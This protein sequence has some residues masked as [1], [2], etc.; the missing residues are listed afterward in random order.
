MIILINIVLLILILS[1]GTFAILFSIL[2]LDSLLRGHDIPTS[3]RVIKVLSKIISQNKSY[4]NNFYDLGCGRGTLSLAI[5]R[6][7]P[8]LSVH[9]IDDN[10]IRIFFARIK[11]IFFRQKINFQK[12][13]IFQ[14]D[15][16]DADIVY[17]YLWYDLMPP[18]EK[19]LQKEL[20]KGAMVIT[21]TSKFP[22][23]KPVQKI[24]TYSKTSN[25][26]DFETLFV[27]VKE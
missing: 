11:T 23:W 15:L 1:L 12:A 2:V 7:H 16:R 6:K 13:D 26:P 3:R 21:N 9:S 19:K 24:I 20:K 10:V 4:A 17:I 25:V 5:K 18:L 8:H 27:Y 14:V 22:N